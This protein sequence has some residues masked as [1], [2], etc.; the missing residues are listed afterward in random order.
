MCLG[1]SCRTCRGPRWRDGAASRWENSNLDNDDCCY[2]VCGESIHFFS[3]Y[4]FSSS[5][6][7]KT[8]AGTGYRKRLNGLINGTDLLS[9]HTLT[10]KSRVEHGSGVDTP[11][12]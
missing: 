7:A 6:H 10:V 4:F 2:H 9:I 5:F 1:P 8:A 11:I 3:F 12:P